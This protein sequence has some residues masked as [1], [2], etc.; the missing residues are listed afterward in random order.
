[1]IDRSVIRAETLALGKAYAYKVWDWQRN[2]Y[3]FYWGDA[4]NPTVRVEMEGMPIAARDMMELRSITITDEADMR[5]TGPV[6]LQD[7]PGGMVLYVGPGKWG[8]LVRKHVADMPGVRVVGPTGEGAKSTPAA[9]PA[10]AP[11]ATTAPATPAGPFAVGDEIVDTLFPERGVGK[12]VG[13]QKEGGLEI[14]WANGDETV[15]T[16]TGMKRVPAATAAPADLI[17]MTDQEFSAYVAAAEPDNP[18]VL[19]EIA[20]RKTLRRAGVR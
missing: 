6:F 11:G 13:V 9:A 12:V 17:R 7:T 20:R 14:D 3:R 2:R 18:V 10:P 15:S 19:A 8:D 16:A 5:V 4:T 1:M